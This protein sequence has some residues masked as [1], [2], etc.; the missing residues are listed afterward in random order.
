MTPGAK[1][2]RVVARQREIEVARPRE[3]QVMAIARRW[4]SGSFRGSISLSLD[5]AVA[6]QDNV[7]DGYRASD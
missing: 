4:A 5:Q 3:T 7:S 6:P 1:D 2:H